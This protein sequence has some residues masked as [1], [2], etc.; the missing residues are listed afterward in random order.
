V[1]HFGSSVSI[2]ESFDKVVAYTTDAD[3]LHRFVSTVEGRD[4]IG[5]V[6][7]WQRLGDR[8]RHRVEWKADNY[9]GWL[10]AH[11]QGQVAMV[12]AEVHTDEVEGA[13]ERLDR[14]LA[15]LKDAI[16]S[17]DAAAVALAEA[18]PSFVVETVLKGLIRAIP[19]AQR[20]AMAPYLERARHLDG[21]PALEDR[22]AHICVIWG[23]EAA[24]G[25]P[26]DHVGAE[27][28]EKVELAEVDADAAWLEGQ[29]SAVE[30]AARAMHFDP[31]DLG[32]GEL[33]PGFERRLNDVEAAINKANKLAARHGW[34]AVPWPALLDQLFAVAG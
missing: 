21:S 9:R 8:L 11:R 6:T 12:A 26:P 32:E 28:A 16:E 7:E 29:R 30:A 19:A 17:G 2:E 33:P 31:R 23:A 24:A 3:H 18:S 14:A 15:E 4:T 10:Q 13:Q 25:R 22:R 27:L 20:A 34:D 5:E 1:A